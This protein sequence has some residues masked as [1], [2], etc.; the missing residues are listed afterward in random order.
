MAKQ[1]GIRSEAP[2][3]LQDFPIRSLAPQQSQIVPV[4]F[5]AEQIDAL[6]VETIGSGHVHWTIQAYAG[7]GPNGT[8][9]DVV[10]IAVEAPD[11]SSAIARARQ[12]YPEGQVYRV[13]SVNEACTLTDGL[14]EVKAD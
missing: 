2:R 1:N 11:L 3:R 6:E 14:R 9:L 4:A 5:G 7:Y 12:L 8:L 13:A 10:Q